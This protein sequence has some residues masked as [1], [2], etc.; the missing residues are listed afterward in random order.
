[1]KMTKDDY[2]LLRAEIVELMHRISKETKRKWAFTTQVQW[3]V[4]FA[5]PQERVQHFYG[6]LEDKHIETA[7]KKAFNELREVYQS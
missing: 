5:I 7:L 6:Y 1:M 4:F 2:R 3:N